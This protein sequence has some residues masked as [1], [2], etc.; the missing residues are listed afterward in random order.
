MNKDEVNDNLIYLKSRLRDVGLSSFRLYNKKDHRFETLTPEEYDAFVRLASNDSIIIQKADKGNTVVVVDRV[1][2]VQKMEELLSDTSKFVKVQFNPKHKVN[3]EIRH[4]LDMEDS[5]KKCLDDLLENNYL[6]QEDH[7]QLKPVGSRPGI[8]YGL[9]KVHKDQTNGLELPA[10]RPILSA[11]KTC[12]Y[13]LAKF[14]VPLLKEFTINEYTVK[15]SFSFADEFA[16]Q[17]AKLFMVSFDVES[18]F[19]NI[20]LDET[21]NIC[22]DR[23]YQGKKK[24]KG[25]LKR[26]F[27]KLLTHATKSSC[28]LFNGTYYCQIDG[29]AM[30]SP[31]GPTLA[32]LFLAYHEEKWLAECPIQFKPKFFRRY[33]DD[34][35]LLFDKQ[36]QVKK[37]LRYL[38]SRHQNMKFTYEEEQN[39]TLAFLDIKITRTAGRFTTSVYRKKTFS[40]VYLNFGSFLPVEYKR[41]LIATLLHRTY[42]ICSDF[43]KLHEEINRLKVIWQK[44]S[45]PL[46]FIDKC[47]KKFLDKLFIKKASNERVDKKEIVVPLVFLGR[48]SLQIKKKLQSTFRELAPGLKLKIV[49]SS[50]NR[51]RSGF[52]FKDRLPREMDSMC[53]YK[54]TCGTCN[55]TYIGETKRHFQVRSY[56][57]MGGFLLTNNRYTY[58]ANNATAVKKHCH[59]L[60]HENDIDSICVVG[61]ASNKFHLRIKES[62][63]ISMVNP[64][65][66]NVQKKSV[67]LCVFG[68]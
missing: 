60:K 48:I 68:E 21:I 7:K 43:N 23:V 61:H 47:V 52:M 36:D 50:P 55:C 40:G 44:N 20:P 1:S 54:F 33:V 64:T 51:L 9:C 41:G 45:F 16:E 13:N 35:F 62:L 57:H 17:D 10:F 59:D 4:I 29:V 19:T 12:T 65:I 56:E 66:I 11:I 3:K 32:N 8:M 53:L 38:N 42:T 15:D 5:I 18:L 49:F 22:A 30:G 39:E 2:Y 25:L 31:L 26:Q 27:K 63:L 46:F 37:F 28:F 34:I 24:V 58:N 67:P 14:F 6:S